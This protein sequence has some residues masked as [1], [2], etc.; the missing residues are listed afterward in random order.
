VGGVLDGELWR[1]RS[2]SLVIQQTIALRG[3]PL[4]STGGSGVARLG[5]RRNDRLG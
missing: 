2:G 3:L 4:G 1:G 5:Y